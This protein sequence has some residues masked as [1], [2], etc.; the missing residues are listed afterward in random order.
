MSRYNVAVCLG[1][2]AFAAAPALAQTTAPA[3]GTVQPR[4]MTHPAPAHKMPPAQAVNPDKSAD[5]LNAKELAAI[6]HGTPAES[7]PPPAP[8]KP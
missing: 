1:L 5:M 8:A 4:H 6:Q 7:P 3:Q 2:L